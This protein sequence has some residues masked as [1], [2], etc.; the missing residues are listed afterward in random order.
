MQEEDRPEAPQPLSEPPSIGP[1]VVS[2]V[3]GILSIM[4]SVAV[5]GVILGVLGLLFGVLHLARQRHSRGIAGWGIGLS[6]LGAA[7]GLMFFGFYLHFFLQV[8]PMMDMDGFM[9]EE[10]FVEWEGVRAPDFTVT[11]LDGADLK[12]S[13]LRGK[14]VIVDMW[15]TW[16]PPCVREI[17]HFIQLAEEIAPEDLA[18]VGI[19][20]EDEEIVRAF[21]AENGVNFALG[22]PAVLPAPYSEANSLPTTFF[23]DRNGVIQ[24]VLRGYHDLDALRDAAT[25]PDFA[26]TPLDEPLAPP[27]S[28]LP[29]EQPL[30]AREQWSVEVENASGLC[31]GDWNGDGIDDILVSDHLPALIVFDRTGQETG[32]ISLPDAFGR[33]E[34]GAHRNGPRLLGYENWGDSVTVVGHDG[35]SPWTYRTSSGVDGAHWG[36]ADGDGNSEMV[37]GF[38]GGGGL[39]LVSDAG[40]KIWFIRLEGTFDII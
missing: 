31:T 18:V 34:I 11:T 30:A 1:A 22:S 27:D 23:I 32:R 29:A 38:N 21:A 24:Q 28:L 17:P 4:F 35:A 8:L 39:H 5:V 12:L 6:V 19:S 14:R 15:A 36:D 20:K 10:T 2:L 37:V 40:K 3:L 16:C 26:G 9:D 33:M 13:D 7:A 25:A